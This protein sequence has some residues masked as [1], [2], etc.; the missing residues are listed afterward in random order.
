ML[1]HRLI[2]Y[3]TLKNKN[4]KTG[5]APGIFSFPLFFFIYNFIIFIFLF[6]RNTLAAKC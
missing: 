3:F 4:K 2:L 1:P 6:D 5:E